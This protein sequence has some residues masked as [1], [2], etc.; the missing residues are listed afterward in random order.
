MPTHTSAAAPASTLPETI[1][2][3]SAPSHEKLASASDGSLSI[4]AGNDLRFAGIWVPLITP[5]KNGVV[6][7]AALQQLVRNML[8]NGIHGLVA[9]GTTAEASSLSQ[10]EQM[11]VLG[12]ILQITAE[13]AGPDY[14]VVMG[15]S[16]SDTAMVIEKIRYFSQYP[17]AGFLV[18]APGYVRPSQQGIVLHFQAIAR[19]SAHP[20]ILYNIPA[21]T[22]VHIE[23]ATLQALSADPRFVAIKES[24]GSLQLIADCVHDTSLEVLSGDDSLLL[25]TLLQGGTGAISAAAH[26]RPELFVRLY[27]LIRNGEVAA[28]H[29][30]FAAMLPLVRLLFA[31]PNPAPIKAVL[32]MQ[33]RIHEELR[34]P[35]T[36]V[37]PAHREKL[38]AA[39]QT[40]A[41]I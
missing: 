33:G 18:S 16:G 41:G 35:M 15:I 6:D 36:P 20:I 39:L 32:A 38:R 13:M 1:R 2:Q 27:Q 29:T 22:G 30:L 4:S 11:S 10:A 19:A 14:P 31:E 8:I 24:S 3:Q 34:L 5:F 40:L 7:T 28:A 37:T 26:V 12:T 25:E 21:R 9:C 17:L 23:L